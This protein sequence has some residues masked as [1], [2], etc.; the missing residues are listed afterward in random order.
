MN[1][2]ISFLN[3]DLLVRSWQLSSGC[4]LSDSSLAKASPRFRERHHQC[5]GAVPSGAVTGG[6]R[7]PGRQ[8]VR[9]AGGRTLRPSAACPAWSESI[10]Q[11]P[12]GRTGA[13]GRSVVTVRPNEPRP[14][15]PHH[16]T[17]PAHELEPDRARI[18]TGLTD[19]TGYRGFIEP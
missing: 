14:A 18:E 2:Y 10:M 13:A 7:R 15:I 6:R 17:G 19:R 12:A 8:Q 9:P 16:N 3:T 11:R 5:S 4:L 1:C